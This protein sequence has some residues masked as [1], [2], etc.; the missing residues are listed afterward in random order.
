[1]FGWIC[2]AN[3]SLFATPMI[4]F[5][6]KSDYLTTGDGFHREGVKALLHS[7]ETINIGSDFILPGLAIVLALSFIK[8][9]FNYIFI[10]S[11]RHNV[12]FYINLFGVVVGT[13]IAL[14][15]LHTHNIV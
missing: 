12:L 10:A 9:I 13:L 3:F 14:I 1:M 6:G 15:A 4:T 8:T 5:I 2:I 11:N 7:S